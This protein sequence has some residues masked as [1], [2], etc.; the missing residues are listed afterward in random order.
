MIQ[1]LAFAASLA[2]TMIRYTARYGDTAKDV[3]RGWQGEGGY[4]PVK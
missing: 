4:N 3:T 2:L 1:S